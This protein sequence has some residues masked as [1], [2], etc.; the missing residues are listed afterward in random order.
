[1]VTPSADDAE[2][3]YPLAEW[4]RDLEFWFSKGELATAD[5]PQFAAYFEKE[6]AANP[7]RK[8]N[9]SRMWMAL[10]FLRSFLPDLVGPG[11]VIVSVPGMAALPPSLATALYRAFMSPVAATN[12]RAITVPLI[13][14]VVK[15]QKD[16]NEDRT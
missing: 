1:M 5:F 9:C 10:A 8:D 6:Q 15:E 16:W 7:R 3:S 14:Q 12:P 11:T 4:S 2:K 13:L